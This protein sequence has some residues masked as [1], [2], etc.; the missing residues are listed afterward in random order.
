MTKPQYTSQKGFCEDI[1][2]GKFSFPLVHYLTTNGAGDTLQV[3]EILQQRRESGGLAVELKRIVLDRLA[4]SGSLDYTKQ[5]L[6]KMQSDVDRCIERLEVMTGRKNWVLR[7][8]LL[9]L[10]V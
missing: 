10:V 1:D 8:C 9:K 6:C 4:K 7:V 2:E 5:R 3:R